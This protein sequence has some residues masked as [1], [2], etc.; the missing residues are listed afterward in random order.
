MQ[1]PVMDLSVILVI[2]GLA[3]MVAGLLF[4]VFA[5]RPT[6]VA[7]PQSAITDTAELIKQVGEFLEKFEARFRVGMAV[8]FFGLALVGAGLFLE[9]NDAKDAETAPDA[10]LLP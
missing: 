6:E 7:T 9:V 1:S 8:M 4:L 5:P 3:F 2:A 10:A